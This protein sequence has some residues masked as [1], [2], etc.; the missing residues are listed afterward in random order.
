MPASRKAVSALSMQKPSE[1]ASFR[2]GITT[3]TSI[4]STWDRFTEDSASFCENS[5]C[6]PWVT[7]IIRPDFALSIPQAP[8]GGWKCSDFLRSL[9]KNR[10]HIALLIQVYTLRPP[11]AEVLTNRSKSSI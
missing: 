10:L 4:F 8:T 9:R 5:V 7:E 3:E 2:Q 11:P 1:R 6:A